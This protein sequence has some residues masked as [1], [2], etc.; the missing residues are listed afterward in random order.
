[1]CSHYQYTVLCVAAGVTNYL[2]C[3]SVAWC[4]LVCRNEWRLTNVV[5]LRRFSSLIKKI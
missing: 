3:L 2:S 1:M 5:I 4:T